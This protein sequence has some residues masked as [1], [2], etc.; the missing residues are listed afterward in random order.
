[1][2]GARV[3]VV[4]GSHFSGI[5]MQGGRVPNVGAE[6]I[7]TTT[8]TEGYF[9]L[10]GTQ[11]AKAVLVFHDSGT[12]EVPA[13]SGGDSEMLIVLE[14]WG[15]VEGVVRI[16]DK[17]A[18]GVAVMLQGEHVSNF[19]VVSDADGRFEFEKL[20]PGRLELLRLIPMG[21]PTA[22]AGWKPGPTG[23]M[24]DV[25]AGET[26]Y[27]ELIFAGANIEGSAIRPTLEGESS[28]DL[29][30]NG[31]LSLNVPGPRGPPTSEEAQQWSRSEAWR[32]YQRSQRYYP[33]VFG[34]GD[35]F[36]IE[37]VEPGE[38]TLELTLHDSSP[39]FDHT[40]RAVHATK[41]QVTESGGVISL[42]E[43][44]LRPFP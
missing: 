2:S 39:P 37:A 36:S 5:Y 40:P 9:I 31:T 18:Q 42:G 1:M 10:E 17:P 41:V 33:V 28:E 38:Y 3:F 16:N 44:L 29:A 12:A 8:D 14:G 21:S 13:P 25:R 22:S 34:E 23:Q 35:R 11:N 4:E 32:E 15:R 19:Q 6:M 27:V 24:V 7:S 43:I 20:A 30:L 26:S